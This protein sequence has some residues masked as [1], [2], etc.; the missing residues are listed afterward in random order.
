MTLAEFY[1]QSIAS[2]PD[3]SDHLPLFVEWADG[4]TVIEVGVGSGNSSSAWLHGGATLW[5]VD[6]VP[7]PRALELAAMVP[8]WEY[9]VGG[10]VEC[11]PC[12]PWNVDILFIDSG[13]DYDL[14][15]T[16]LHAYAPHVR[17]G[18]KILLHDTVTWQPVVDAIDDF[19]G[20]REWRNDRVGSGLGI[21]EW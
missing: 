4:K 13:H 14:T 2:T 9:H 11:A 19:V 1:Q 17:P 8:E 20:E 16:E 5:S 18:G 21:I 6:H 10:S 7:M 15:L 3:I 12:A